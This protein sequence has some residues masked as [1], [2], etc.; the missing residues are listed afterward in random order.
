LRRDTV[1]L[2]DRGTVSRR[3]GG[4]ARVNFEQLVDAGEAILL[5]M[6]RTARGARTG[7][8]F[9]GISRVPGGS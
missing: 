5:E 6:L 4:P 2:V 8:S 3:K 1:P 7:N 9:I